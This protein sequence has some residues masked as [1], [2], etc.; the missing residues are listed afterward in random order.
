M[1]VLVSSLYGNLGWVRTWK[2]GIDT[3]GSRACII[4]TGKFDKGPPHPVDV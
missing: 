2:E 4:V 1:V 3:D